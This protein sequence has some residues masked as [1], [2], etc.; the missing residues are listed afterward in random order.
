MRQAA[1]RLNDRDQIDR[2]F[3]KAAL[4]L[5]LLQYPIDRRERRRALH[6]GQDNAVE[7]AARDRDEIAIAERGIG[8][9]DA[10]I[11]ESGARLP[12]CCRDR[13]AGRHLLGR[14]DRI[15]KVEND[16]VGVEGHRLFDTARV[17]ARGEQKTAEQGNR[18][19]HNFNPRCRIAARPEAIFQPAV[20]MDPGLRRD[21]RFAVNSAPPRS[22][23]LCPG[24]PSSPRTSA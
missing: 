18:F 6:L 20:F 10:D 19:L 24:V 14:R 1:G 4:A 11:Q 5:D 21:D 7:P 22:R 8:G 9:V 3:G 2:A 23:A 13:I 17:I 15:F 12:E 16:G